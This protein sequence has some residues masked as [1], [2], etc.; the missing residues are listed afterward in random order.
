MKGEEQNLKSIVPRNSKEIPVYRPFA[1]F[2]SLKQE[3]TAVSHN[4]PQRNHSSITIPPPPSAFQRHDQRQECS[5]GIHACNNSSSVAPSPPY[6][7]PQVINSHLINPKQKRQ[8]KPCNLSSGISSSHQVH[9]IVVGE[10]FKL[11]KWKPLPWRCQASTSPWSRPFDR[12]FRRG[13][14]VV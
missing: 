10:E 6:M 13:L 12:G 5:M 7:I 9:A 4:H 1:N 14:W 8:R 3:S 2:S 11:S